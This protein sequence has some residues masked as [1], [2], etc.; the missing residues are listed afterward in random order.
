MRE[1]AEK[2]KPRA[3]WIAIDPH[4]KSYAIVYGNPLQSCDG[5]FQ[6]MHDNLSK[7]QAEQFLNDYKSCGFLVV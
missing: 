2:N 5:D 3:Y 6:I 1:T 4:N 7:E